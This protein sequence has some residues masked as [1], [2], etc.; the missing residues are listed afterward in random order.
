LDD[1][2][3][4]LSIIERGLYWLKERSSYIVKD[5]TRKQLIE[6]ISAKETYLG[7]MP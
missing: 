2:R 3:W 7:P 5:G 6:Y 1:G 4:G